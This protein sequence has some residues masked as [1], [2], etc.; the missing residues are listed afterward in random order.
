MILSNIFS[1]IIFGTLV[2]IILLSYCIILCPNIIFLNDSNDENERFNFRIVSLILF[3]PMLFNIIFCII[4]IIFEIFVV[5]KDFLLN[6]VFTFINNNRIFFYSWP[7]TFWLLVQ[8]YV[9]C[10]YSFVEKE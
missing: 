3:S 5:L 6:D 8:I 2:P 9:V 1:R 4:A 10:S 7:L